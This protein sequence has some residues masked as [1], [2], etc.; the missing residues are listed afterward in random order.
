[1]LAE[2][3]SYIAWNVWCNIY[4]FCQCLW[5]MDVMYAHVSW[6]IVLLR[7]INPWLLRKINPWLPRICG[8]FMSWSWSFDKTSVV[9]VMPYTAWVI[10]LGNPEN[11]DDFCW[12]LTRTLWGRKL[13]PVWKKFR[14]FGRLT[15]YRGVILGWGETKVRCCPVGFQASRQLVGEFGETGWLPP[16]I[17]SLRFQLRWGS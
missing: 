17:K 2:A 9:R 7:K 10:C 8:F 11:L 14:S 12:E 15:P 4:L 5:H 1:M 6:F 3:Q 13:I 16:R